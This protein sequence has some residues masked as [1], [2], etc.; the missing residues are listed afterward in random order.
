MNLNKTIPT[1]RNKFFT[2]IF[3]FCPGA[4]EMYMGFLH[5]GLSLLAVFMLMLLLFP[6]D[7]ISPTIFV[8]FNLFTHFLKWTSALLYIWLSY[9]DFPFLY[10]LVYFQLREDSSA[11]LL[12]KVYYWW[13]ILIYV[14]L[15]NCLSLLFS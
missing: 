15:R 2:F 3:S 5:N 1:R 4:A 8:V 13:I 6:V 7:I 12:G 14:C 9:W 11:F 10:I